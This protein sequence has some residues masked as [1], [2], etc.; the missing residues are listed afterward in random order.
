[1][2]APFL[3][4]HLHRVRK[5]FWDLPY[6]VRYPIYRAYHDLS[7]T[8]PERAIRRTTP[9]KAL[10]SIDISSWV[11]SDTV[12][13]LGSGESINQISEDRWRAIGGH[14]SI[15][16]NFWFLHP[17]VP[18]LYTTYAFDPD[19]YPPE[20][21]DWGHD[22]MKK[23]LAEATRR[24]EA[25][26]SVPKIIMHVGPGTRRMLD[27]LPAGFLRHSFTTHTHQG[28]ARNEEELDRLLLYWRQRGAFSAQR[29]VR[30]LFKYRASVTQLISLAIAMGYRR[31]VLCGIDVS[32]SR[33]FYGDVERYPSM[34][35][36]SSSPPLAAHITATRT[37][38]SLDIVTVV[39]ALRE[40]V[41][42]PQG[43][44]LYVENASSGLHPYVPEAPAHVY[45]RGR[46]K[47]RPARPSLR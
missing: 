29:R 43:I 11:R 9:L 3:S 38:S 20:H 12:F 6:A 13:I 1:M 33:Y 21:R 35:G 7:T 45:D 40:V 2:P 16:F 4:K 31:I 41:L 44:E 15:G 17:F 30:G 5:K 39:R 25:Y 42:L 27:G 47:P 24:S 26:E 14:D 37:E 10:S 8:V 34:A 23:M 19:R 46:T 28:L 22:V 36:F 18:T 32:H